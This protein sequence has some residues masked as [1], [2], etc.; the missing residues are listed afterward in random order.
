MGVILFSYLMGLRML[1]ILNS[2][3]LFEQMSGLNS[4]FAKSEVLC[5]GNCSEWSAIMKK[6]H[7]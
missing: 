1:E 6:N 7:M 5:F 3:F 4:N 2:F